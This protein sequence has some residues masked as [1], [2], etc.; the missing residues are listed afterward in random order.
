M[1]GKMIFN[2]RMLAYCEDDVVRHVDVP[3][4]KVIVTKSVDGL[5]ELIFYYG[6]ND[7][8]PQQVCSVSMGDVAEIGNEFYRCEMV[9]WRLITEE[10]LR[11]Y[12]AMDRRDRVLHAFKVKT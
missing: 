12:E 1:G 11:E 10:E 4:S 8:Q 3:D 6:Q 5:L 9:G 7:F 2:V